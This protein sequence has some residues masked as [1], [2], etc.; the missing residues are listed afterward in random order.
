VSHEITFL[1]HGLSIANAHN[2]LQGQHDFPLAEEGRLQVEKLAR[3]WASQ[4]RKFDRIISSPLLR[5]SETARLIGEALGVDVEF[6]EIW[7]ERQFGMAEGSDYEVA[8][9]WYK[10]RPLPSDYEPFY[11]NG[12]S[13]WDLFLRAGQAIQGLIR[14]P[15]GAYLVVSHGGILGATLRAILGSAPRGGRERPVHIDFA[16]TGYAVVHYDDQTARW[17]IVQ[18]NV[19][20][21]LDD[22]LEQS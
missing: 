12:E 6:D 18:L 22:Q 19:T 16:N 2:V 11:E 15:A 1:R 21:H 17:S 7:M 3:H 14:R 10:D 9:N 5:A 4:Q 13:E 20:C 8:R